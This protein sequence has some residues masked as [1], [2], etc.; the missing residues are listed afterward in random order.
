MLIRNNH[1]SRRHTQVND[2][3]IL[4]NIVRRNEKNIYPLDII[5]NVC[6]NPIIQ[7]ASMASMTATFKVFMDV[8]LPCSDSFCI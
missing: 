3:I 5:T 7:V 8:S 2:D 4:D 1:L 6:I